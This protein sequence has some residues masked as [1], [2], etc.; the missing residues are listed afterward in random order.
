M[1][2]A[3]DFATKA[4]VNPR[5]VLATIPGVSDIDGMS[6][7]IAFQPAYQISAEGL[8]L[9]PKARSVQQGTTPPRKYPLSYGRPQ[10]VVGGPHSKDPS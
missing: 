8:G 2:I 3:D 5:F 9:L 1:P 4:R 10:S 7:I 6:G